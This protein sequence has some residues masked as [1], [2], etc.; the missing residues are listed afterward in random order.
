MIDHEIACAFTRHFLWSALPSLLLIE[1]ANEFCGDDWL[2]LSKPHMMGFTDY[3]F[4][5]EKPHL[6]EGIRQ[7][8]GL[9]LC[10]HVYKIAQ[11]W[12]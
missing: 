3:E 2:C 6:M 7:T 10:L 1:Y 4:N 5:I 11:I 8:V 9:L 12:Q